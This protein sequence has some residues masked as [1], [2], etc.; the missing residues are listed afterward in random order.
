[1]IKALRKLDTLGNRLEAERKRLNWSREEMAE[2]G[3][4]STPTQ[5]YYDSNTRVPPL[6]YLL[7]ISNAGADFNYLLFDAYVDADMS[8]YLHLAEETV[9]SAFRITFETWRAENGRVLS[10][11]DALDC[12]SGLLRELHKANSTGVDLNELKRGT[13][14]SV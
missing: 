2:F 1:M 11:D 5:R 12:F 14:E 9:H 7:L 4:V 8:E 13:T 6:R 3:E 10:L